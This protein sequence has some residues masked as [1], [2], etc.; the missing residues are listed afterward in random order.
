MHCKPIAKRI[1]TVAISLLITGAACGCQF[2]GPAKPTSAPTE[3]T[4]T[5]ALPTEPTTESS[6]AETTSEEPTPAEITASETSGEV[7]TPEETAAADPGTNSDET[8]VPY[9]KDYVD[10]SIGAIYPTDYASTVSS[11]VGYAGMTATDYVP[12]IV[13]PLAE[14]DLMKIDEIID[15]II[16]KKMTRTEKIRAVHDWIVKNVDY[17]WTYAAQ[18]VHVA[19]EKGLGVCNSYADLFVVFMTEL[20]IPSNYAL[21]Y[22][23][24]VYHMWNIVELED[25]YWYYID[26]TWDDP[27]S[28]YE[29]RKDRT[30]KVLDNYF[31][32]TREEFD[33]DHENT[34]KFTPSPLATLPE[35]EAESEIEPKN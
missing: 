13:R 31:L 3:E 19:L 28:L 33:K 22:S 5:Y 14:E 17:D 21:G 27:T 25:H 1:F 32:L 23:R 35:T 10:A 7:T 30:G 6:V 29:N 11:Y 34:S 20:G 15:E 12:R 16:E 9:D 26:M 2:N 8:T 4:R 24:G 18:T